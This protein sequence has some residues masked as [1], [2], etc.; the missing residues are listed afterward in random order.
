M[1]RLTQGLIVAGAA[2]L[3]TGPRVPHFPDIIPSRAAA[4]VASPQERA[5]HQGTG[6]V[7]PRIAVEIPDLTAHGRTIRVAAGG[8]LQRAIDDAKGGDRIELEPRATYEGP[9][10]LKAKEGDQWIVITSSAA[11]PES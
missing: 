4:A 6:P 3:L 11:P 1:A 10:H 9:F 8:N 5:P 2:L 7:L